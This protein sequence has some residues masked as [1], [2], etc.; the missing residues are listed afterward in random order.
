MLA[1]DTTLEQH[2]PQ[3]TLV[4]L[5]G[6]Q[7]F[8]FMTLIISCFLQKYYLLWHMCYS[9]VFTLTL[10]QKVCKIIVCS[11]HWGDLCEHGTRSVCILPL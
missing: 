9:Y 10:V 3:I 6:K 5:K 4:F 11:C 1:D 2:W 7:I 8:Y